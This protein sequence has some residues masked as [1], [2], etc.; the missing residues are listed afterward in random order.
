MAINVTDL[1]LPEAMA[2]VD[3]KAAQSGIDTFMLMEAA[4]AHVAAQ[5]LKRF[6]DARRAVVLTGPGNNGGDGH[7]AARLLAASGVP[8]L[9]HG[10]E[11]RAGTDAERARRNFP[12]PILPLEEY[13]AQPGDVVIDALYG[14]GLARAPDKGTEAAFDG[15]AASGVPVLAVDLPSGLSGATGKPPGACLPA[16]LTVTFAAMKPGHVLMPGAALCGEV[17]V[18]D[19]GI[20]ARFI[21]SDRAL[22]INHDGFWRQFLRR[23]AAEQHKYARGHLVVFSGPMISGGA[24]RLAAEAALR[25]GAGAVTLAAPPGA[26]LVN[27]AHV[28]AV[29]QRSI[30]DAADLDALLGD[31]RLAAFVL[32]P[33]FGDRERARAFTGRLALAM[34]PVVIDADGLTAYA[35]DTAALASAFAGRTRL[36]VTPHE[37]E[38][39]RLFPDLADATDLSKIDRALAAAAMINGVVIYKGPDTVIAAPDG[40]AAVNTGAPPDLATAGSGD[41]LSGIIGALAA[42]GMPLFEAACAGVALHTR[43]ARKI[44]AAGTALTAESLCH[45]VARSLLQ[46]TPPS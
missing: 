8:V 45:G 12:G 25:T 34:K 10:S 33:G 35:G 36:A 4:G 13:A 23:A 28:T 42:Q 2:A 14:A 37:G 6:P 46:E 31:P 38:F 24:A 40:R 15:I 1:F 7:V 32:G 39:R 3:R 27:A 11:P 20:P 30:R 17:V 43:A 29:M 41:V 19:I 9:Q 22:S 26:V 18:C 44:V 5:F 21:R 16:T